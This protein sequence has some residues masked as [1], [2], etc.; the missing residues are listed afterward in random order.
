MIQNLETQSVKMTATQTEYILCTFS[1][2]Q[3][4]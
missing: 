4:L 3:Q 1:N 2:Q